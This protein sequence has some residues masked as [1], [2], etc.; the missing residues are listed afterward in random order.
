MNDGCRQN[1]RREER[2]MIGGASISGAMNDRLRASERR[3]ER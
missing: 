3:E 2:G 1:E